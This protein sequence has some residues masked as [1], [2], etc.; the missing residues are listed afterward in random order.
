MVFKAAEAFCLRSVN[1]L[2]CALVCLATA[3]GA[4]RG[5]AGK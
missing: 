3:P 1:S 5:R 4:H 2:L